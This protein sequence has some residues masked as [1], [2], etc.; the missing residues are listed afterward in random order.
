MDRKGFAET[1]GTGTGAQALPG[2]TAG[3]PLGGAAG[4]ALCQ[5]QPVPAGSS[6]F[7]LALLVAV[8]DGKAHA[9]GE[10]S[11]ELGRARGITAAVTDPCCSKEALTLTKG[12]GEGL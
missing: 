12:A 4:A 1:R 6:Q 9:T 3:Q 2:C 10:G 11:V 5:T 7:Q 8:P